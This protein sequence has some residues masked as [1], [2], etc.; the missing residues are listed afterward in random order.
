[1]SKKNYELEEE[2]GENNVS[3]ATELE[4]ITNAEPK[5]TIVKVKPIALQPGQI[6]G[7]GY[8]K[9]GYTLAPGVT[10]R[11]RA[12]YNRKTGKRDT[13]LEVMIPNPTFINKVKTPDVPEQ[14]LYRTLMEQKFSNRYDLSPESNFWDEF[15]VRLENKTNIFNIEIAEDELRVAIMRSSVDVMPSISEQS[16]PRYLGA[17]FVFDDPE[18]EAESKLYKQEIKRSAFKKFDSLTPT[19]LSKI[20][21][22]LQIGETRGVSGKVVE[23]K[24]L[25]FL[26]AN[27]KDFLAVANKDSNLML[28]E[29]TVLEALDL[30]I[31]R[32]KEGR[33]IKVSGE[34]EGA[35]I[36]V[37]FNGAVNFLMI[38]GNSDILDNII[39]EIVAKKA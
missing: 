15:V 21:R 11:I 39:K 14:I 33:I 27:P 26:E 7:F 2:L 5:R 23:S 20:Y 6:V 12:L 9:H 4:Y 22:I 17:K 24:L 18:I 16:N 37:D 3:T 28:V 19:Q 25:D 8:E 1:M 30:N 38:K 32:K 36:G 29:S 34:K 13:G 31:L 10:Y 35:V